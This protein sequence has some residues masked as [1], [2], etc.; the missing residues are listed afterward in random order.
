MNS[1]TYIVGGAILAVPL[2]VGCGSSGNE[3]AA[4]EEP[5]TMQTSASSQPEIEITEGEVPNVN[6][7]TLYDAVTALRI[8]EMHYEVS[9]DGFNLEDDSQNTRSWNVVGQSPAAG[10]DAEP[11]DVIDLTVE[12]AE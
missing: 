9:G 5:Q 3:E 7:R 12:R 4:S 11:R 1:I 6:G 10:A 8:A 2:L